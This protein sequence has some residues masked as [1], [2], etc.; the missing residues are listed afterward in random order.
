MVFA[1]L[2][3]RPRLNRIANIALSTMYALTIIAGAIGEWTYYI[4]GSVIEVGLLAAVVYYAWTWPTLGQEND[5]GG[6]SDLAPSGEGSD[7]SA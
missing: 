1:T 3:L 4:L 7:R 5:H 2:V 6:R